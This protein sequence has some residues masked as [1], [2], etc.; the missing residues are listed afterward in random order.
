MYKLFFCIRWKKQTVAWKYKKMTLDVS[1]H[2]RY[3]SQDKGETLPELVKRYP[4]YTRTSIYRHSKIP[5]GKNHLDNRH[6][7]TG[8]PPKLTDSDSRKIANSLLKLRKNVRNCSSTEI[9]CDAGI[10]PRHISNRTVWR[11]LKRQGYKYTQ[12]RRNGQL[13][14]TDLKKRVK[15]ARN[16]KRLPKRF[17]QEGVSF[18][19]DRTGWVHK[20]DPCKQ[21]CTYLSR[22]WKKASESLHR[23]CTAKGKKEGSAGRMGNVPR[24]R[25]S[26]NNF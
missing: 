1:I 2:F 11:C 25:F 14:K 24:Y 7:N 13:F 20:T 12:C 18:Y 5:V 19:L 8:R 26:F 15:F 10:G 23:K 3:L 16:C 21:A 4:Q 6:K 17:W 9:Q 22:M